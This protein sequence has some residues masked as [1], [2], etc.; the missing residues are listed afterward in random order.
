M[1]EEDKKEKCFRPISWAQ[2]LFAVIPRKEVV[3]DV[4][5]KHKNVELREIKSTS[6]ISA[7]VKDFFEEG[8]SEEDFIFH[9]PLLKYLIDS[10]EL[11]E[12]STRD[13]ENQTF[14]Q[15][16]PLVGIPIEYKHEA[17]Q[18]MYM[19]S[20]CPPAKYSEHIIS[21]Q[22]VKKKYINKIFKFFFLNIY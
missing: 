22:R 3:E 10:R 1:E 16:V 20:P 4:I 7:N 11:E 18:T 8:F 15:G 21:K 5:L 13:A 2:T 19:S 17:S 12:E 14:L 9:E 6:K